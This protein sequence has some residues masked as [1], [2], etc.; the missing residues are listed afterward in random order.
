M[1]DSNSKYDSINTQSINDDLF[2]DI[3]N[4]NSSNS[5]SSNSNSSNSNKKSNSNSSNSNNSSNINSSNSNKKSSSNSSNSNNSSNI[6]SSNSN[7]KSSS[8]SSNINSSNSNKKSSSNSSTTKIIN[9][10]CEKNCIKCSDDCKVYYITLQR[11]KG[12]PGPPGSQGPQG[13]QGEQGDQGPRGKRGQQGDKG[14]RGPPGICCKPK[15]ICYQGPQGPQGPPGPQGDPGPKG[16]T[17]PQGSPG[18]NGSTGPQGSPGQDGSPGQQGSQGSPGEQGPTGP[19]GTCFTPPVIGGSIIEN[20]IEF[21]YGIQDVKLSTFLSKTMVYGEIIFND[22]FQTSPVVS[23]TIENDLDYEINININHVSTTGFKYS[24]YIDGKYKITNKW[25]ESII[26]PITNSI[27]YS[28]LI[29]FY[30]NEKSYI[31]ILYINNVKTLLLKWKLFNDKENNWNE[32]IIEENITSTTCFNKGTQTYFCYIKDNTLYYIYLKSINNNLILSKSKKLIEKINHDAYLSG[33]FINDTP[34]LVYVNNNKVY[35]IPNIRSDYLLNANNLINNPNNI[36]VDNYAIL[37]I[38]DQQISICYRTYNDD[39]D[40][41]IYTINYIE[42]ISN[43]WYHKIIET[44]NQCIYPIINQHNNNPIILYKLYYNNITN[45]IFN[46]R[47]NNLWIKTPIIENIYTNSNLNNIK[48]IDICHINS[49]PLLY[50]NC[51][52]NNAN[53]KYLALIDNFNVIKSQIDTTT[54]NRTIFDNMS[55]AVNHI[56]NFIST[57]SSNNKI[58]KYNELCLFTNENI[59]IHWHAFENL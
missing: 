51:A 30:Y 49:L 33:D 42:Q 34:C 23:A 20:D 57:I 25:S 13:K 19:I 31:G 46:E 22:T 1:Y 55:I 29:C 26:I 54:T 58:L 43:N 11:F 44:T 41:P 32:I 24:M 17:G 53:C 21:N 12:V 4:S 8:N 15:I 16:S 28:K 18:Q 59:K 35:Y 7:K 48:D 52:E 40:N 6:N 27:L 5:N 56:D 2:D 9:Q 10:H 47:I 36:D 39:E 50:F 3:T 45:I 14:D 37:H 38:I